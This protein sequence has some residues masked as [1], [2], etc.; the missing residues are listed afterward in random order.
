[1]K[2]ETDYFVLVL[3][4]Q[5]N[6]KNKNTKLVKEIFQIIKY[7]K[8]IKEN[9]KTHNIMQ[10]INSILLIYHTPKSFCTN[11]K[12]VKKRLIIY[13]TDCYQIKYL[14]L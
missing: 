14:E 3:A 13:Y 10:T 5:K 8:F 11:L 6:Q 1:M 7:F 9:K 4:I 2:I 12:Y